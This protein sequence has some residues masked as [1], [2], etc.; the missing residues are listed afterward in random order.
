MANDLRKNHKIY[1]GYAEGPGQ[2]DKL[3]VVRHPIQAWYLT[4]TKDLAGHEEVDSFYNMPIEPVANLI[5]DLGMG[6]IGHAGERKVT[7]G[8]I[9]DGLR[10]VMHHVIITAD[11]TKL[12]DYE[13]GALADYIAMLA[14][15]Q[16]NSLDVCQE[17]PSIINLL[18]SG[19][20]G[21]PNAISDSDLGYL[22]GLYSMSADGNLRMQQDG[23][24]YRLKSDLSG[25]EPRPVR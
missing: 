16:L 4:A 11:P 15:T 18:A 21:A 13:V 22:R 5:A 17:L 6:G 19:C 12:S 8:R 24:A 3:A 14:L 20:P 7:G 9:K 25:S 23:I 1:L 10:T 2:S